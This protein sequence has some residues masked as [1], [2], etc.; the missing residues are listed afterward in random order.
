MTKEGSL[1]RYLLALEAAGA[2]CSVALWRDGETLAEESLAMQRGQSEHLVPMVRRCM[3]RA[4]TPWQSLDA[5]AVTS[6]PGGFTGVRIGLAAA[7][8]LALAWDL[9]VI[10]VSC[11][12]ALRASLA[13]DERL[14]QW[15]LLLIEAKR[16][17]VYVQ[18]FAADG[19][20][21]F[22]PALMSEKALLQALPDEAF[23]LAGDAATGRLDGL[24]EAGFRVSLSQAPPQLSAVA[25][26]A[27]AARQPLPSRPWSLPEPIYLREADTTL[28]KSKT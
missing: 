8:G 22:G 10:G 9:P 15:L 13:A 27:V 20:Q 7:Q 19:A 17:E 23:L 26:A 3:Q 18:L 12:D 28:A 11:F 2:A 4:K 16:A 6:G 24:R 5:I 14:G 21:V 1:P 25:V